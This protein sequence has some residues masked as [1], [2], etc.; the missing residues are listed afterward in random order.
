MAFDASK[1]FPKAYS[2]YKEVFDKSPEVIPFSV[3]KNLSE[4]L[5]WS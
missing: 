2:L 5:Y 3:S 4:T 1:G